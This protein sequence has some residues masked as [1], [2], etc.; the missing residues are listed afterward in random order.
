MSRDRFE[1][2]VFVSDDK[3]LD[4]ARQRYV[5]GRIHNMVDDIVCK[6]KDVP[7][8]RITAERELA[9]EFDI[10]DKFKGDCNH[11]K[12]N[13][14]TEKDVSQH[15]DHLD[16]E[17]IVAFVCGSCKGSGKQIFIEEEIKLKYTKLK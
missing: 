13:G 5:N 6:V 8:V 17:N 11:C 1:G 3:L 12:G 9:R 2:I 14:Y 15:L 16:K 4:I 7:S 10:L